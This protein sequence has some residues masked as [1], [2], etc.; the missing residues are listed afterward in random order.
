MGT[1]QLG[2]QNA[3]GANGNS[4]TVNGGILDLHGISPTLGTLSGTGGMIT[5]TASAALYTSSTAASTFAGTISGALSL[6]Q[7]GPGA[8]TLSG[9]NAFSGPIVSGGTRILQPAATPSLPAQ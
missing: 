6:A 4:L 7:Q 3:L 9:D 1:L 2:S 8:L 5:T